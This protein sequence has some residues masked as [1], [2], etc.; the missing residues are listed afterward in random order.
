[1]RALKHPLKHEWEA[2]RAIILGAS[3]AISEGIKWRAPSFRTSEWFATMNL[4][5]NVVQIIFHLGVKVSTD[6]GAKARIKDPAGLLEWLGPDRA[7][8]RFAEMDAIES[9]AALR[10]IVRQ[11][12][13]LVP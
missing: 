6:A 12:I 13:A 2:V 1:M 11:W 8:M 10:K 3:P 9:G 5:A 4:R 7:S